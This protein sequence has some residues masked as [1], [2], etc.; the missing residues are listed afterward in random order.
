MMSRTTSAEPHVAG[1]PVDPDGEVICPLIRPDGRRCLKK[2]TGERRYRSMQEHIRRA[3]PDDYVP[4]LSATKDSF[5]RMVRNAAL[6]ATTANILTSLPNGGMGGPPSPGRGRNLQ[7]GGGEER[8]KSTGWRFED[9]GFETRVEDLT[10]PST[11]SDVDMSSANTSLNSMNMGRTGAPFSS[12]GSE[13][14]QPPPLQKPLQTTIARKRKNNSSIDNTR[15]HHTFHPSSVSTLQGL[16]PLH[17]PHPPSRQRKR[18]PIMSSPHLSRQNT[19]MSYE[20]SSA[21]T[22][23]E[24]DPDRTLEHDDLVRPASSTISGDDE[25]RTRWDELVFV[26]SQAPEFL[27]QPPPSAF[28]YSGNTLTK[29]RSMAD[30]EHRVRTT[31]I[32]PPMSDRRDTPPDS[33]TFEKMQIPNFS[34]SVSPRA[35]TGMLNSN[36]METDFSEAAHLGSLNNLNKAGGPYSPQITITYTP[37]VECSGCGLLTAM[38]EAMACSECIAGLCRSCVRKGSDGYT[39]GDEA[40]GTCPSCGGLDTKFKA[41]RMRIR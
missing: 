32:T 24:S 20:P 13:V 22:G 26:A 33:G 40:H 23:N 15:R 5:D 28:G 27:N 19:P 31:N 11:N 4:R 39:D 30:L 25:A 34:R 29:S 7:P 21:A 18:L 41:V 8:A 1:G 35:S 6:N 9:S 14:S 12:F 2:C 36:K 3:H 10:P 17:I 37:K 38:G 16:E